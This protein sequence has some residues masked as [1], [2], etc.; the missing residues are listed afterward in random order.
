MGQAEQSQ[1]GENAVVTEADVSRDRRKAHQKRD[2]APL[3]KL[4]AQGG[5]DGVDRNLLGIHRTDH[6]SQALDEGSG[7]LRLKVRKPKVDGA[8][9]IQDLNTG[10]DQLRSRLS[11]D[12]R[13]GQGAQLLADLSDLQPRAVRACAAALDLHLGTTGEVQA[14]LQRCRNTRVAPAERHTHHTEQ[15]SETGG[16]PAL[17][18]D[19]A[20]PKARSWGGHGGRRVGHQEAWAG[21]WDWGRK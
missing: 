20:D 3:E 9:P 7:L 8:A 12:L 18:A 15:H 16:Q 5:P 6:R 11:A 13:Q 14:G 4:G 2:Q 1:A 19:S 10:I 17:T 21:S